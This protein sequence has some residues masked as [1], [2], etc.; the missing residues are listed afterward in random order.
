MLSRSVSVCAASLNAHSPFSQS[1][2]FFPNADLSIHTSCSALQDISGTT[3]FGRSLLVDCGLRDWVWYVVNM[4]IANG[5]L[6][7]RYNSERTTDNWF[8]T[9]TRSDGLIEAIG[10]DNLEKVSLI[11]FLFISFASHH[12]FRSPPHSYSPSH[13]TP[14]SSFESA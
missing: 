12:L 4:T 5:V 1:S 11:L 9:G 8:G 2:S 6:L 10:N 14:L 7:N 3:V 13:S